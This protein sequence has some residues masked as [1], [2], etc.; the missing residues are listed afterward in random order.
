MMVATF[1]KASPALP[2]ASIFT[3]ATR[4]LI[5]PLI[6]AAFPFGVIQDLLECFSHKGKNLSCRSRTPRSTL[7]APSS[8]TDT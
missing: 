2:K 3:I 5:P 8:T 7:T 6:V 4:V 1:S